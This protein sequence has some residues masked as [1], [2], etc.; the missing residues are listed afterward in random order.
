M[1]DYVPLFPD[2]RESQPYSLLAVGQ[3]S[4][5]LTTIGRGVVT[6][7]VRG[8][9]LTR[10]FVKRAADTRRARRMRR[11]TEHCEMRGQSQWLQVGGLRSR[12]SFREFGPL[13]C[14]CSMV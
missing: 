7:N 10:L 1:N 9:W 4:C 6:D 11:T 8:D 5:Q 13:V 3:N 2:G 14:S 12:Q